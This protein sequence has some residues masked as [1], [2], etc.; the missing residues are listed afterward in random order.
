M[1]SVKKIFKNFISIPIVFGAYHFLWA[2]LGSKVHKYPSKSIF[3]IGVT[4]TKGKTTTLEILNSIFETAQKRTAVLSSL[5]IKIGDFSAKNRTGNSMPGKGYIQK[6]LRDAVKA[7]C[8]YAFIEVTSQGI[9]AHRH[10]FVNW[11][12]GIIT[13]LAPEHI[14]SHGSF[15]NYRKAKL[16][17]LKYVLKKGGSVF[18]NQD[19][20]DSQFFQKELGE[21]NVFIYSKNDDWIEKHM[22]IIYRSKLMNK[23]PNSEFL[24]SDFN[25]ENV[26]VAVA[27]AKELGISDRIIEQALISFSGVEGRMDAQRIG[28]YVGFVDYAHTPESLEAIYKE[29]KPKPNINCENPKLVCVL[30][31]AGGGRDK[32]K[33]PK[34]GEI[35]ARYCD[36]IILTDEDSYDEDVKNIIGEIRDGIKKTNFP[37][38]HIYEIL[39]R[40]EAIKFAAG[41]LNPCD[42]LVTT[43]KGSEE[44]IHIANGKKIPW[45]EK[46]EVV[47]ALIERKNRI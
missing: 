16:D 6:F 2:F 10:R 5:R 9:V 29:T 3:V 36:D 32:W 17:F 39:D 42:V 7:K 46:E 47:N 25:K 12:M 23:N 24:M 26:A 4:G 45:N 41:L 11:N 38:N 31:A 21:S 22:S 14:E 1:R 13:N 19:F 20:N 35:A 30:G 28:D 34:M 8:S 37:Q 27:V 33:R 18:I 44:W 43:G 40:R 15:E